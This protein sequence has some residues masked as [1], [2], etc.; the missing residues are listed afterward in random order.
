MTT[1]R[2]ILAVAAPLLLIVVA[3]V[4]FLATDPLRSLTVA[5][6]PI[7][8]VT[9]ERQVLNGD[10]I[11]LLVRVG[12]TEPVRIAQVQVDGAYWTFAQEPSGE[13]GNL[14]SA[15]L[16]IPYPWV[17]GETHHIALITRTGLAFEH[18]IDVAVATPDTN[19]L[20]PSAWWACSSVSCRSPSA[21]CSTRPCGR[22]ARG[23]SVSHW[24]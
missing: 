6:P 19:S 16:R 11:A 18:T 5:V 1:R 4:A 3:A 24:R 23:R 10:G 8:Q 22:A 13:L 2:M 17:L 14:S 7:E 15:W 12:G 9:V 20:A 21:C